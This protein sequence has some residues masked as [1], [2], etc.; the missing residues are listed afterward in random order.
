TESREVKVSLSAVKDVVFQVSQEKWKLIIG[1]G[2]SKSK[3]VRLERIALNFIHSS[4]PDVDNILHTHQRIVPHGPIAVESKLPVVEIVS[5]LENEHPIE[6]SYF[7]GT[8]LCNALF[9]ML[10]QNIYDALTGFIH[11]VPEIEIPL[12]TQAKIIEKVISLA[13]KIY[14]R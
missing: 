1:M 11:V 10:T 6:V 12:E 13:K 7:A 14:I 8:Y 9:Y 5:S 3:K 2:V 4:L